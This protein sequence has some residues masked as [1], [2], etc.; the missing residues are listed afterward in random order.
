MHLQ[1][2]ASNTYIN[3]RISLNP[4][5]FLPTLAAKY[6]NR[7]NTSSSDRALIAAYKEICI[8]TDRINLPKTIVD[9]ANCKQHVQVGA[10]WQ[11]FERV[12]ERCQSFGLFVYCVSS[13]R[14]T[15][16][17]QRHLCFKQDQ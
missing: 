2:N 15:V 14:C 1:V 12:F 10:R 8:M 5:L 9:R 13:I 6:Q 4:W 17:I 16:Y 3:D 7:R 11:E